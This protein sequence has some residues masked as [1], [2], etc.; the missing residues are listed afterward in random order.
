MTILTA[1]II[2]LGTYDCVNCFH[3]P[4]GTVRV[5]TNFFI[6]AGEVSNGNYVEYLIWL[7]TIHGDTSQ[8]LLKAVP[9]VQFLDSL[10]ETLKTTPLE[11]ATSELFYKYPVLG[12]DHKQASA[13]CAWKSERVYNKMKGMICLHFEEMALPLSPENLDKVY[14][15]Y[16]LP[17]PEEWDKASTHKRVSNRFQNK[18]VQRPYYRFEFLEYADPSA[19]IESMFGSVSEMTSVPGLS[20]GGSYKE[21]K[22]PNTSTWDRHY[23]GPS[24]WVGFRCVCEWKMME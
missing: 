12:V 1:L 19:G 5:D 4:S 24:D 10:A 22:T 11:Y 15:F 6:E 16:R 23:S 7:K 14:P 2:F 21:G 9:R 3:I 8:L 20:K 13:Y 17:T 18:I